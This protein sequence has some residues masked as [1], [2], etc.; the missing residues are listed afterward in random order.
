MLSGRQDFDDHLGRLQAFLADDSSDRLDAEA[1]LTG[2]L[3]VC[4]TAWL[5][6]LDEAIELFVGRFPEQ[7]GPGS[8][9]VETPEDT[10]EADELAE[11]LAGA[12]LRFADAPS[13][14]EARRIVGVRE[15]L[16]ELRPKKAPGRPTHEAPPTKSDQPPPHP[17]VSAAVIAAGVVVVGFVIWLAIRK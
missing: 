4:R 10:A 17:L 13:V 16:L 12:T 11:F 2:M 9:V 8:E 15:R 5:S 14:E 6:E 7:A 3:G 1:A